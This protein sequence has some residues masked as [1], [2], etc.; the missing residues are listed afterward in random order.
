MKKLFGLVCLLLSVSVAMAAEGFEV[1][2]NG[3]VTIGK[4]RLRLE[5]WDNGW[6]Y[7]VQGNGSF[8]AA[9]G[10]PRRVANSFEWQGRFLLRKGGEFNLREMISG[11]EG[12]SLDYRAEIA[13]A[14]STRQFAL[15]A[16]LPLTEFLY[17][18]LDAD[19]RKFSFPV[20]HNP[21]RWMVS[22]G[23]VETLSIP[24]AEGVLTVSG[25]MEVGFFDDRHYK[26]HHNWSVRFLPPKGS[27][28]LKL[29]FQIAYRPYRSTPLDLTKVVNMG[30]ADE[31][32]G[33]RKGGWSDQGAV[34]DLAEMPTG[35]MSF[36][37]VQFRVID[38]AENGGK[39][40][41]VTYG[42]PRPY[43]PREFSVALREPE[44]RYLYLLHALAWEP[45]KRVPVGELTAVYADGSKRKLPVISGEEV[46][47]FWYPADRKRAVAAWFGKNRSCSRIGLFLTRY[48]FGKSGKIRELKLSS[49][50]KSVWMIVAASLSPDEIPLQLGEPPK[51]VISAGKEY[52]PIR[53][54]K[55]IIP[56]SILDFSRFQSASAG[57]FGRVKQVNGRL[58][59][60]RQP[61]KAVRFYGGNI[62]INAPFAAASQQE[63]MA[64]HM[65]QSGYNLARLHHFDRDLPVREGNDSIRLNS[66]KIERLD[67]L[68][69]QLK[70]NGIYTIID[71]FTLR[72]LRKGE[73]AELPDRAVAFNEFKALVFVSESAMRNWERFAENFLNHVNPH[74]GLAW[75]DDP[76]ILSISLVNENTIDAAYRDAPITHPIYAKRFEQYCRERNLTV[77]SANRERLWHRFLL[78]LQHRAFRRQRDFLRRLG[79]KALLTDQNYCSS[80]FATL[81]REPF[82]LVETHSYWNHPRFIAS[83]WAPPSMVDNRSAVTMFG[84]NFLNCAADRLFGKPFSL[85]EWD[86][87]N[88][89]DYVAEGAFLVGAYGALQDWNMVCRFDYTTW[90]S[91]MDREEVVLD[92][93]DIVNDPVRMLSERAG[94]LFFARGDVAASRLKFPF[95]IDKKAMLERDP[96]KEDYPE[97]LRKMALIGQVG[98]VITTE[99]KAASKIENLDAAL[100]AGV[101]PAGSYDRAAQR[102]T[103]STGE[104]VLNAKQGTFQ[105]VTPR[106]EA[107]LLPGGKQSV[108][109][110]LSVSNRHGFGAF[111]AAAMDDAE[112]RLSRRILLLHLTENRNSGQTFSSAKREVMESWGKLPLLV[113]RGVAEIT[114]AGDF[115]GYKLYAVGLTGKRLTELVP[116]VNDGKSLRFVADILRNPAEPT[117][118]YELVKE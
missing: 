102:F 116:A 56:G 32:D 82:D 80:R 78:D 13:G 91:A 16:F 42:W 26:N 75:K 117:L 20:K 11:L 85:S 3:I 84:G 53:N 88:P 76:S 60:E 8:R 63:K 58:E 10:F 115:R 44:G 21:G 51:L 70:D 34:N 38:P 101:L 57:K 110:C 1:A 31:F 50:G 97:D 30:F 49:T 113:R 47:N 9:P 46:G 36:R 112:L 62:C 35:E 17:R 92:Y 64:R 39:S 93:F 40:C 45:N 100:Q 114:L 68:L 54:D 2:D 108:G 27:D 107:A 25:P 7:S 5:H 111:L 65:A 103:S 66:E 74:T 37:G 104:L 90:G 77:T 19:G 89:Y 99:S 55:R 79:V 86:F 4:V 98:S 28:P 59:F 83:G 23:R 106:S 41:L 48:D 29:H 24:L 6:N 96:W 61:G 67:Y 12:R 95:H 14:P 118:V 109:N 18:Q 81:L 69:K 43:F 72:T 22:L 15:V 71:L 33:D 105:V 52:Q 73:I 94:S 87:C